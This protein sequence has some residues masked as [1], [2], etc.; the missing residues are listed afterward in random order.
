MMSGSVSPSSIG[1]NDEHQV[2]KLL[3]LSRKLFII[4]KYQCQFILP[5]CGVVFISLLFI[6]FTS[7]KETLLYGISTTTMMCFIIY[8]FSN[9]LGYQ[10]LSYYMVCKYID[11]KLK[12]SN[13]ELILM[14]K[15]NH[16]GETTKILK[17]FNAIYCEIKEYDSTYISKF[18]LTV[19]LLIG[20]LLVLII[21]VDIFSK[22]NLFVKIIL[23]YI[24]I[25]YIFLFIF[26][27]IT[28]ASINYH[29]RKTYKLLNS[30]YLV[31][32]FRQTKQLYRRKFLNKYRVR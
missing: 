12:N 17:T 14:K 10:Y 27:I 3:R 2:N 13:E 30:L 29:N 18:L 20:T 15:E 7:F 19:W 28:A 25:F 1:L 24:T 8:Y 32:S 23:F 11:I 26:T 22:T 31:L 16:H 6:I 4:V 9:F 5:L 21:Y